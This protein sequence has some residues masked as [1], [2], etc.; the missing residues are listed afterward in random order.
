MKAE[1]PASETIEVHYPI[2]DSVAIGAGANP[3]AGT[4]WKIDYRWFDQHT[5]QEVP[6]NHLYGRFP[7]ASTADK[8]A[9]MAAE[10]FEGV[11]T[12]LPP[13]KKK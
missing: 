7:K 2:N 9:R 11:C 8:I 1:Y 13:Q 10:V 4:Y 3:D 5:L 6:V 12:D